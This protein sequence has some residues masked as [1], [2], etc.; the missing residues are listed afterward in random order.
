[1]NNATRKGLPLHSSNPYNVSNAATGLWSE[2]HEQA[3][4]DVML[5]GAIAKSRIRC[6]PPSCRRKAD[7]PRWHGPYHSWTRKVAGTT[8]HNLVSPEQATRCEQW[9]RNAP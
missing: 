1:M 8:V 2:N 6:N 3:G 4:I 7:P 5:R 9:S